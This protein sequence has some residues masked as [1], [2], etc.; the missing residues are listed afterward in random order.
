MG[1]ARPHPPPYNPIP[2]RSSRGWE[3]LRALLPRIHPLSEG[4]GLG[5]VTIARPPWHDEY[6]SVPNRR[7]VT[8][9][10]P[11][12]VLEALH[13]H[14]TLATRF[15]LK[16]RVVTGGEASNKVCNAW[17]TTLVF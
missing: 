1:I 12:W 3:V 14:F 6:S 8:N 15:L 2:P 10:K 9:K 5:L 11:G 13:R 4:I 7:P 17:A 16:D